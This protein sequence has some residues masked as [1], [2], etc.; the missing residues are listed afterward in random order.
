MKATGREIFFTLGP[1]LVKEIRLAVAV[2]V[3][4]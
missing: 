1:I 2:V 4:P 3:K